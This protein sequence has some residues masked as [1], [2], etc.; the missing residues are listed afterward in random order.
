MEGRRARSS[1]TT[2]PW[3]SRST[4]AP[5]ERSSTCARASPTTRSTRPRAK[6][7][8][9]NGVY[10]LHANGEASWYL[11]T[12]KG[13]IR[14]KKGDNVKRGDVI[15]KVGNSGGSAQ[16]HLH[17]TLVDAFHAISVPWRCEDY[18]LIAEDGTKI[19]VK[20]GPS[21]PKANHGGRSSYHRSPAPVRARRVFE[22]NRGPERL[23]VPI[24]G[25]AV[26]RIP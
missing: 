8:K 17:F 15:A 5:T 6:F 18:F 21:R 12:Q 7:E 11:H 14:V 3:A 13:S 19:K 23:R 1:R 26:F 10:I 16:P 24:A 9:H 20:T 4:R 22:E 25:V 2:T